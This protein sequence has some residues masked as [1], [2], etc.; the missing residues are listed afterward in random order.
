MIDFI[1]KNLSIIAVIVFAMSLIILTF[2]I[3]TNE[4]THIEKAIKKHNAVND[5]IL[6]TKYPTLSQPPSSQ[7]TIINGDSVRVLKK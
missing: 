1:N 6:N 5:A 4:L 2:F 7:S 3:K